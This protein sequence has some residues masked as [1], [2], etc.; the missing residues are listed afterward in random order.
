MLISASMV[1]EAENLRPEFGAEEIPKRYW[2]MQEYH[3]YRNIITRMSF[4]NDLLR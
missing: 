2:P 4:N 3:A 1:F